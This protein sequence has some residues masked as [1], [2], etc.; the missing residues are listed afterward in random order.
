M[1]AGTLPF[2]GA[3]QL[4]LLRAII[5]SSPARPEECDPA[6]WAI[7]EQGLQKEIGNRWPTMRQMGVALARWLLEQGITEDVSGSS[8]ESTWTRR[9]R[10]S[11][12][13]DST[14][15]SAVG[16]YSDRPS[17]PS[18]NE[19]DPSAPP[20][21]TLDAPSSQQTSLRV[22][23]VVALLAAA[24]AAGAVGLLSKDSSSV[25]ATSQ[26]PAPTITA[27][28]EAHATERESPADTRVGAAPVISV[29]PTP[30]TTAIPSTPSAAVERS[31][32]RPSSEPLP[33]KTSVA[34]ATS[35]SAS[36]PRLTPP[37]NAVPQLKAPTF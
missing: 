12:S 27:Q 6:L 37:T 28:T 21:A 8:L 13:S 33:G 11:N 36:E 35:T 7:L 24:A 19:R 15:S 5:E 4:A 17:R 10:R 29:D 3:N 26:R 9:R 30:T 1:I 34:R 31:A 14:L 20:I 16:S 23:A 2:K 25:S 32:Q 18:E 22:Y